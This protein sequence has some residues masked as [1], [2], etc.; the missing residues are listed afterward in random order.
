MEKLKIRQ[1][2]SLTLTLFAVFFGAGNMI[3]PPAMGQKAGE[4][5]LPALVGFILT[6]AGIALL[7]IVAVVLVGNKIM[8]LG[9]LV[10]RH[11]SLFLSI[12]VYLLIGPLFAL[13]RTG[14][15]SYELAVRPYVPQQYVWLVSLGVTA[16]FFSLTYY[17]SGNPGKIVDIIGK[18][19]TPILIIS[20]T[21]IF[22]V[23]LFSDKSGNTLQYG[24]AK[25]AVGE[26]RNIAF[27]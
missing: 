23:C 1:M 14:S 21:L 3:F 24:A 6:D 4:N 9:D 16:V 25:E 2:M 17:F 27:F 12:T 19:M 7:G 8:D 13:P 5:Y 18:Y 20:I 26:Y 11:F 22:L 15:V 10:S